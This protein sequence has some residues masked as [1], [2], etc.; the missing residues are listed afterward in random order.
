[1]SY[2]MGKAVFGAAAAGVLLAGCATTVDWGGPL[3][4]YR[5]NYD[6]RPVVSESTVTVPA[7]AVATTTYS[8]PMTTYTA[9]ATTTTTY[10][11][12]AATTYTPSST[13]VYTPPAT[14]YAAPVTTYNTPV[15]TYRESGVVY[16]EPTS[17]T[18][19]GPSGTSTLY[20]TPS[21]PYTDHGQ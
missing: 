15:T 12:P 10:T 17:I 8:A 19:Y 1:M 20:P 13:T 4:H 14:T 18:Y 5:Y 2:R 3:G 9:P 21:L 7:P 6:S 16:R 11:A